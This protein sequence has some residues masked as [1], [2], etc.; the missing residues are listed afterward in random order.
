[1]R[2]KNRWD[3][4]QP[5]TTPSN[6]L[7]PSSGI[8][9]LPQ[10]GQKAP[11]A[12]DL[13][14]QWFEQLLEYDHMHVQIRVV[15]SSQPSIIL[16]R[17]VVTYNVYE[18]ILRTSGHCNEPIT[19]HRIFCSVCF[20]PWSLALEYAPKFLLI[21]FPIIVQKLP[22]PLLYVNRFDPKGAHKFYSNS[23]EFP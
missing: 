20:E 10:Y 4:F 19:M 22:V 8:V 23:V 6:H 9:L 7:G 1:M 21:S 12:F 17:L 2:H 11:E 15:F 16:L 5:G 13:N 3:H 18:L 14:R